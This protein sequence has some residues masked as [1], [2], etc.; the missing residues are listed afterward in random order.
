MKTNKKV[1]L[2]LIV[3]KIKAG[4]NPA[5]IS[6]ELKINPRT[7][8]YY[9][10]QLTKDGIIKK[11]SYGVWKVEKEV[12]KTTKAHQKKYQ[13][14]IRGHAFNWKVK[15]P[16]QIDWKRRLKQSNIKYQLIG[17]KQTTPRIIFNN[18]KIW[19]TKTGLVIYEPKSFFS[20]SSHTSKGYAVFE[21]DRTIKQLGRKLKINLDKYQFTTS[22]EHYGLIKNEL[23]RQYNDKKEKLYIRDDKGIWMWI[24][25][26]HSLSEL[27]NNN[28]IINR[29]VQNWYNDMKQTNFKVTPS[30]ITNSFNQILQV[31]QMNADNIVK[32][33]RVLDEMLITLKKIQESLDDKQI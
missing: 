4:K 31:Q 15:F 12:S 25:D 5:K 16:F 3:S 9:I 2:Y 11:E 10:R 33:Q 7:L 14:Q 20:P 18:K 26:S 22:R 8:Q 23:A 6:K 28:P 19:F 32:H 24:D 29:G 1:I 13:K 21:L 27:E 17:I 30:F